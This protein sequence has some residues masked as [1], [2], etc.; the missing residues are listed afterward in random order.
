MQGFQLIVLEREQVNL[1]TKLYSPLK[2]TS[3]PQASPILLQGKRKKMYTHK[4]NF[5]KYIEKRRMV[6]NMLEN[7]KRKHEEEDSE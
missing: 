1:P 6:T 7:I 2:Y 5:S 3:E 4:R